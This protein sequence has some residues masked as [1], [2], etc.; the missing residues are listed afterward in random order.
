MAIDYEGASDTYELAL[1]YVN[2]CFTAIFTVECGLKLTAFGLNYFTVTWNNFDFFVVM[3]SIVEI[4][5]STLSSG[6]LSML[7]VGPQLARVL[8]VMRVS[9]ILRLINKYQGLQTLIQTI[10]F[11]VSSLFNVFVLLLLVMF[12]YAVLGVFIFNEIKYGSVIGEYRN[13]HNFGEAMLILL[14]ISTGEDWNMIM[15]D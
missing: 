11:S 15:Y 4:L 7:R 2:L 3:S 12:I 9:R 14:V 8:R 13:F 6:S 5:F 10:T 1:Y